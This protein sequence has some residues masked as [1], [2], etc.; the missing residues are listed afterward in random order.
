MHRNNAACKVPDCLR[1]N[2]S[3]SYIDYFETAYNFTV[4]VVLSQ[5]I[6]YAVNNHSVLFCVVASGFNIIVARYGVFTRILELFIPSNTVNVIDGSAAGKI[7]TLCFCRP[8]GL[9]GVT[10][11]PIVNDLIER[12]LFYCV[13]KSTR[14]LI[15]E[16]QIDK[17][18][19]IQLQSIIQVV[20]LNNAVFIEVRQCVTVFVELEITF[21]VKEVLSAVRNVGIRISTRCARFERYG[22]SRVVVG[23]QFFIERNRNVV[24][25]LLKLFRQSVV[26]RTGQGIFVACDVVNHSILRRILFEVVFK[27]FVHSI[28]KSVGSVFCFLLI[29]KHLG[30]FVN[31]RNSR[32]V[33]SLSTVFAQA[34]NIGGIHRTATRVNG[35]KVDVITEQYV[36]NRD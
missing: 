9:H 4:C 5:R 25:V 10:R 21:H 28:A 31:I 24:I 27:N 11:C 2:L 1:V 33:R 16:N 12:S 34:E 17:T 36:F 15:T 22:K 18:G 19:L 13:F 30:V 7:L 23:Y 29:L 3:D 8:L 14:H 32:I 20:V 35:V 26:N 6:S